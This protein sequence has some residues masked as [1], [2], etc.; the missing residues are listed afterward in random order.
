MHAFILVRQFRPAVYA[1]L[2]REAAAAGAPSPPLTSGF[3]FELCAGIIDK[4]G[5]SLE[6]IVKEEILEEVGYDVPID[7]IRKVTGFLTAVGIS[8]A[9][10]TIFAAEIDEGMLPASLQR[11]DGDSLL[12]SDAGHGGGVSD[13]GEAIE[14]V[15]LPIDKVDDFVMDEG[16]PKSSGAMFALSWGA[17]QLFQNSGRLFTL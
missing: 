7:R 11:Q 3:T 16:I 5:L 8:G 15:A 17:R 1:A 6:D 14:V 9:R 10:Q 12:A 2:M 13:H 4:P